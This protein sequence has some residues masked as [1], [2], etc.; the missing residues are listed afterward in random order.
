MKRTESDLSSQPSKRDGLVRM[1]IQIPS[2]SFNPLF[3]LGAS[4]RLRPTA[5]TGAISC[6]LR[7]LRRIEKRYRL[8]VGRREGQEGRQYTLVEDTA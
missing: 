6:R 4:K 2:S 1:V 3:C 8:R 5:Q 7:P